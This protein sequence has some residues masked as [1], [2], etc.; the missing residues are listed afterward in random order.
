MPAWREPTKSRGDDLGRVGV[1]DLVPQRRVQRDVPQVAVDLVLGG[2]VSR[3]RLRIASE[4][5]G[6]GT[7]MAL[8]VSL[9]CSSGSTLATALAAPVS[10]MTMF[11]AARA[12]AA[13]A[14]VVVVDQVLVVGVGVAGLHVAVDDAEPVVDRLEHRDD[15]VGGAGRRREDRVRSA[16]VPLL[17]PCTMLGM[18]PLPGAVRSTW[19]T[20]LPCEV[21]GQ[22]LAVAPLAGVVDHDGVLDAVL[23]VVDLRG[24]VGVDDVDHV[25]VGDDGVLFLVDRDGAVEGAVDRVA[26]QQAGA[27]DEV[28][29]RPAAHH[30][31]RRRSLAPPPDFSIRMRASRRPMRPKP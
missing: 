31:A 2:A 1:V 12:A 22:A 16:M 18:S 21:L 7:R 11:S 13:V 14:L 9:P 8:P 24:G 25:A 30:V 28:V 15:G 6:V 10:V 29:G 5:L 23:G 19:A 20:P 4:T 26:A 27:L 17:M 3:L